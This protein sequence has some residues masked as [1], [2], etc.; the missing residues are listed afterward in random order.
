MSV[1]HGLGGGADTAAA[2]HR[3]VFISYSGEDRAIAEKVC[4]LLERDD[5]RCWIAPRDVLPGHDYGIQI[6]DAI[7]STRVMV[8]ILSAHAN[9]SIFVKNEVERAIS[10]GKVV[11]PLRIQDVQPSRALELFVSRSQWIDAWTPPLPA[12]IHLLA[13]AIHG[14]LGLPTIQS[15]D[16]APSVPT[17]RPRSLTDRIGPMARRLKG[18]SLAALAL[19]VLAVVLAAGVLFVGGRVPGSSIGSS[20]GTT[21]P[22]SALTKAPVG[23]FSPTGSLAFAR[24]MHTATLLLDGRVLIAGGGDHCTPSPDKASAGCLSLASAELY[25]P[26]TGTF[27]PTGSMARARLDH[28]ATLLP[29]GRVLIAGGYDGS[30]PLALAELYDPK[31]GTFSPTGS[32]GID[33]MF[34]TAT[35][36]PDGRVLIAGGS[37]LL[38]ANW[39]VDASAELYDPKTGTF[40]PTG[41]MTSALTFHTAAAL[42]DGRVLI[43]GGSTESQ[44][45]A[46]AEM[47]DPKAG[48]FT[49]TGSLAFARDLHTATLLPDG[50]VLIAGGFDGSASVVSAELYNP[51]T[52]TFSPIGSMTT[53]RYGQTA[54][55]LP[56]GRV[57]IAGGSDGIQA[58]DSAEFYQP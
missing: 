56:D 45:L 29:D 4:E 17:P 34:A 13:A 32:M 12:R 58:L 19:V 49:V 10:K 14:L 36:L 6:L 57:F 42:S 52:G 51:T 1:D 2:S 30:N 9:A 37:S 41:S 20:P 46:S 28:T 7:E 33:R 55:L 54:T 50:R 48:T 11:V 39:Q 5:L 40:N 27:S 47:Y 16:F 31:T 43:T 25:D 23:T 53:A 38:G 21:T 3:Q 8:L 22:S 35:L 26:K 44:I 18:R 24:E 15:E